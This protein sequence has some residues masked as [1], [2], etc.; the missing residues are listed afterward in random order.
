MDAPGPAAVGGT[1]DLALASDLRRAGLR[2]TRPRLGVY[3]ALLE[4]DGHH[5]VDDI[6]AELR[7]RGAG[8]PRTSVYNVV[9]ALRLAGLVMGADAG[10]GRALYEA[11]SPPH[12]HFVCRACA[13]VRDVPCVTGET[14]CLGAGSLVGHVDEAQIIFRGLCPSCVEAPRQRQ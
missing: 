1:S 12:H 10:P 11:G 2:V 14:P 6:V 4:L 7:G 5:S 3:R 13:Q 8:L 9:E